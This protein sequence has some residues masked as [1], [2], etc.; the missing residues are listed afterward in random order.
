MSTTVQS[1]QQAD[2]P[3]KEAHVDAIGTALLA[4][5]RL[6]RAG[7]ARAE[8]EG[9][10]PAEACRGDLELLEMWLPELY[11]RFTTPARMLEDLAAEHD[12]EIRTTASPGLTGVC[13]LAEESVVVVPASLA[14]TAAL[15]QLRA[16]LAERGQA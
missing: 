12:L 16:Q 7:A 13:V 14:P 10:T 8:A 5:E 11:D 1:S 4:L 3:A 2:S 9:K 15:T 6:F